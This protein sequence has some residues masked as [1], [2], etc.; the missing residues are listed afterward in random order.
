MCTVWSIKCPAVC[1]VVGITC[2][3]GMEHTMSSS[4]VVGITCVYGMAH[5]VSISMWCTGSVRYGAY[6]VH[7][8]VVQWVTCVY[9]MEHT[10][11]I[12]MCRSG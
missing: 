11:S 1:G 12:S 7:Q 5:T 3:Y 4:G 2:V 9:V 6:S 10:M 8:S